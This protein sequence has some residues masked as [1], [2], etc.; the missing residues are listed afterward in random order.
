[1]AGE[2]SEIFQYVSGN[3]KFSAAIFVHQE[4]G[5]QTLEEDESQRSDEIVISMLQIAAKNFYFMAIIMKSDHKGP[6]IIKV[7][8]FPP[9]FKAFLSVLLCQ[10]KTAIRKRHLPMITNSRL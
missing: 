3:S 6:A 1:L 10:R 2:V 8:S 7:F 9:C 5:Y 4:H